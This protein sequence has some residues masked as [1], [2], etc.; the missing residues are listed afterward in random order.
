[1]ARTYPVPPCAGPWRARRG[2]GRRAPR[3][4]RSPPSGTHGACCASAMIA[5]RLLFVR[6]MVVL[7]STFAVACGGGASSSS[8]G[9]SGSHDGAAGGDGAVAQGTCAQGQQTCS[10]CN[11][12]V[13][14]ATSC[15]QV[16]CPGTS[17]G[18]VG[19]QDAAQD[20][21][22]SQATVCAAGQASCLDCN[23]GTFCVTGSC[24][25]TTCPIRDAGAGGSPPDASG[26]SLDGGGPVCPGA[27]PPP[28]GSKLCRS[29]ADCSSTFGTC[30]AQPLSGCGGCGGPQHACTTDSDCGTGGV[31]VCEPYVLNTCCGMLPGTQ[32]LPKCTGTSCGADSTC[33]ASGHCQPTLCGQGYTCA[34]DESCKAGADAGADVHGCVP[35]ACT[36]GF[37]CAA[38]QECNAAAAGADTHGCAPL[39]CSKGYACPTYWQCGAGSGADAHG[40]TP[41][42]CSSSA[43]CGVNE[44]CDPT[45]PGRGCVDRKCTSDSDCDC[46]ACVENYCR[47]SLWV[48][49]SGSA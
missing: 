18:G 23:G 15:P 39:P 43:P 5:F 40:C 49:S 35:K 8:D 12:G 27:T 7:G 21:A 37:A 33:M 10:G 42:P 48:C 41:I 2:K 26:T 34:S 20:A 14:C 3:S 4:C 24:P 47:S 9:S 44:S 13:F 11:G 25:A 1:M 17:D 29:S 6:S 22:G 45:Q 16:G 36:D 19:A 38:D 32:C 46:G 31:R 28:V 30:A